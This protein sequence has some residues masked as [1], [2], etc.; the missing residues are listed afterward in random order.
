MDLLD[1]PGVRPL[2][3]TLLTANRPAIRSPAPGLT[4]GGLPGEDIPP[5]VVPGDA[6][7][8]DGASPPPERALKAV[9]GAVTVEIPQR[10]VA[11]AKAARGAYAANTDRALASDTRAFVAWCAAAGHP[12]LPATAAAVAAYVDAMAARHA[13][14][15]IR[16]RLSS[17][18][19]L[20]R[21]GGLDDP[22]KTDAVRFALRRVARAKGTRR[23]QAT[24]ITERLVGALC[25]ATATTALADRRDRALLLVARDLLARRSELVGIDVDHIDFQDDG[26]ALLLIPR[27]KTDPEGEGAVLWLAPETVRA[28]RNWL[29][30]AGIDEGALFRRLH[31]GGHSVGG[32]LSADAVAVIWKRRARAAG[33]DPSGISGHSCRVGMSQDL[34]AAGIELPALMVAGRWRSPDMP[35]RYIERIT[36]AR[37][38]VAR[39]HR[40]HGGPLQL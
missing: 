2:T 8:A 38:A 35:A 9:D 15:T 6:V 13:V 31:K 34:A 14:S 36:A 16:R 10:L 26:S 32:R 24:A 25:A 22:T 27:S 17:I 21:A 12:C 19:R 3:P 29:D 18:A 5:R 30:A 40:G 20:H 1:L 11:Y 28:V 33:L 39:Y 37:G 4:S 23:R 7:S